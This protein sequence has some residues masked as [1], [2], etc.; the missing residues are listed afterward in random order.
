MAGPLLLLEGVAVRISA[1]NILR[2]VN[3]EVPRG[4]IVGL[5]GRNGAGKTTTLRAIMGLVP[6]ATGRIELDGARLD[7]VPAFRRARLGI[8]YLP[9]D[10]RLIGPLSVH[11]NLLAPAQACRDASAHERLRQ[12]LELIPELR[13][14]GGRPGA[15]LS[16][17]QQKLVALARSYVVGSRLLLLD[18]P[19]EG[20]STALSRRLAGVVKEFLRLRAG[21]SVLVA[22]SDLKRVAMLAESAYVIERGEIAGQAAV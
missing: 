17:G 14:L 19:F 16:G 3:L 2:G 10:R 11:D 15:S 21:L 12:V 8:G 13:E 7:A 18:E 22:E 20:V 9:E 1:L 6:G 5:A 4:A